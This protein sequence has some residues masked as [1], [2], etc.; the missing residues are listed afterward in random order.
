[1]SFSNQKFLLFLDQKVACMYLVGS[2][3]EDPFGLHS[4]KLTA[5]HHGDHVV[6]DPWAQDAD[7][8]DPIDVIDEQSLLDSHSHV[9]SRVDAYSHVEE[10]RRR[11]SSSSSEHSGLVCSFRLLKFLLL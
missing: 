11:H 1:M 6:D 10:S 8:H 9:E 5:T 2:D 3:S 7:S 4:S